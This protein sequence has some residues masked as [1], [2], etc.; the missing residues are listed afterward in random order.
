MNNSLKNFYY[1]FV[2]ILVITVLFGGGYYLGKFENQNKQAIFTPESVL[3]TGENI[4]FST[5]MKV[6]K[7]IDE[8]YVPSNPDKKITDQEKMMGAI[9]GMVSSFGDPYTVFLDPQDN[10]SFETSIS[11]NF[12]GVG[13][14]VGIEEEVLTVIAPLKNSPAEK[15]GIKSGDKVLL[16]DDKSTMDMKIDDAIK[17]IR[18]PEGSEVKLG[19]YRKSENKNLEIKVKR[20]I[21]NIPTLDYELKDGVFII[22][23]YSFNANAHTQFKKAMQE[24]T[25]SK[26]KKIILDLR[27]NPGGFLESAIDISSYFLPQGKVVVKEDFGTKEPQEIFRSKGYSSFGDDLKM[28][29][30]VDKGSAS[31][32]EIV[33]GA[34]QYHNVAKLLGSNTFGKGSVQEL[35][36]VTEDTS[37]K[38]TIARW[39]TPADK[40]I[41]DGGLTPDYKVEY[42]EPEDENSKE[43][44]QLLEA[45]KILN[46]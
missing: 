4:D 2:S 37:L 10:A 40:S 43:D 6:W 21:I 23:L 12:E 26:T 30:L 32:S 18:G 34:L 11:G 39:L 46:Q 24:F 7:L 8:K 42:K 16:I 1:V 45:I 33:A 28:I 3:A 19:I 27:G 44:N 17:L 9:K 5:F 22:S 14:E 15:A 20:A 31:A 35:V 38:V 25:K 13:M 36:D 41:S 29:I